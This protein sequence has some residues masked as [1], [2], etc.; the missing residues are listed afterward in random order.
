MSIAHSKKRKR[1]TAVQECFS[2]QDAIAYLSM[3][4]M[5]SL[6][7][8]VSPKK[9]AFSAIV[10]KTIRTISPRYIPEINFSK[11]CSSKKNI[12]R[13]QNI[14]SILQLRTIKKQQKCRLIEYLI[15]RIQ[16]LSIESIIVH[17]KWKM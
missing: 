11:I 17:C 5:L 6:G 3:N 12:H 4:G 2:V 7:G 8:I 15:S 9:D 10:H 1:H 16:T 13:C 14:L